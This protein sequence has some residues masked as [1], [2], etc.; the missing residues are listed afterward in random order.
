MKTRMAVSALIIVMSLCSLAFASD[1]CRGRGSADRGSQDELLAQLPAEKETLY[2]QTMREVRN[3]GFETRAQVK[4]LREEIKNVVAADQFDEEVFRAKTKSL[5]EL[6]MKRRAA[7]DE[8]IATLAKQFT[9]DERQILVQL[10]PGKSGHG[11]RPA[12]RGVR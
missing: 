11:R 9:A 5:E 7:M 6:Q 8:A 10:L 1:G 3:Q 4:Q 12:Q 2:H